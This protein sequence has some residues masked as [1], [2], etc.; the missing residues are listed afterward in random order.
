M[1]QRHQANSHFLCLFLFSKIGLIEFNIYSLIQPVNK[2]LG[3]KVK[4][5][6][7]LLIL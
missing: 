2:D 4:K 3:T 1:I 5:Y 7:A 6:K